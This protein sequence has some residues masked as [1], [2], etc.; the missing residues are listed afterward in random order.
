[1]PWRRILHWMSDKRARSLA[2]VMPLTLVTLEPVRKLEVG[3]LS[4]FA[5]TE[6]ALLSEWAERGDVILALATSERDELTLVCAHTL[7]EVNR[8]LGMLPSVATGVARY[9]S[10]E[11]MLLR[12]TKK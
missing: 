4:F 10:R 1:M 11:V 2:G 8:K 5:E 12:P 3:E 9:R 6:V 7:T